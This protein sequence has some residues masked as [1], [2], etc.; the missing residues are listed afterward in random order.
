MSSLT[1][2]SALAVALTLFPL[3]API[4]MVFRIMVQTPPFW[5]IALSL[6][7]CV[8]STVGVVRFSAKIY[9]VGILMYGKRPSLGELLRWLRYT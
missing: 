5:Q 4:L 9:R 8:A 6:G 7:L 2:H 1:R 3:S